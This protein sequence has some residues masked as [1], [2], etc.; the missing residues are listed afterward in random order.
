LSLEMAKQ[1][2][3]DDMHL[4]GSVQSLLTL[5]LCVKITKDHDGNKLHFLANL[6]SKT[7]GPR[8]H[9]QIQVTCKVLPRSDEKA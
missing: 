9:V 1:L 4:L 2:T 3:Q 5:Q 6:F 8:N 7:P